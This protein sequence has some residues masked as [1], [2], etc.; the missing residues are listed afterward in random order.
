MRYKKEKIEIARDFVALHKYDD[1]EDWCPIGQSGD[2][3]FLHI[4]NEIIKAKNR[5]PDGMGSYLIEIGSNDTKTGNPIEFAV[6][7]KFINND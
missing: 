6:E 4:F 5:E 3:K 7:E 1:V 2:R